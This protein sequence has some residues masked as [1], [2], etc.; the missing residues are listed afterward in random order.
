M[1]PNIP[2]RGHLPATYS[3]AIRVLQ[4]HFNQVLGRFSL[5]PAQPDLK[6]RKVGRVRRSVG[7]TAEAQGFHRSPVKL[8]FGE[9]VEAAWVA[10]CLELASV[11]VLDNCTPLND[12]YTVYTYIYKSDP[13]IPPPSTP[14]SSRFS[15]CQFERFVLSSTPQLHFWNARV[16]S[17][18][19]LAPDISLLAYES[20]YKNI[21]I[22]IYT[23]VRARTAVTAHAAHSARV[24]LERAMCAA[25]TA[26]A[27]KDTRRHAFRLQN[28]IGQNR[29]SSG[30]EKYRSLEAQSTASQSEHS[31]RF[32]KRS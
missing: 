7:W 8:R 30:S 5:G 20:K 17:E 4:D 18:R 21:Y 1:L 9:K 2:P 6:G 13:A 24:A 16:P 26:R 22:Y 15:M 11:D 28:A 25:Q 14:V 10:G 12:N 32:T 29:R 19:S 31:H 27:T 23:H 3:R